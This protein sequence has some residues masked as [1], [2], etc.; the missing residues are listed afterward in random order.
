MDDTAPNNVTVT[1]SEDAQALVVAAEQRTISGRILPWNEEGSTSAGGLRF[2]PKAIRIPTDTSRVKLLRDH[3]PTGTPVGVMTAWETRTDGLYATFAIAPTADGDR[4]LVEA[5]EKVRDS[6][7]V[8]V[9]QLSRRG[10]DVLDSL[11]RGVAL[12][13]FPAFASALVDDVKASDHGDDSSSVPD[14]ADTDPENT[15]PA[16]DGENKETNMDPESVAAGTGEQPTETPAPAREAIVPTGLAPAPTAAP[17]VITASAAADIIL[18]IRNGDAD[19]AHAALVDITNTG[20]LSANPAAWLGKLWDGVVYQRRIIPAF[21]TA[22]LTGW[23]AAGW[24]WTTKP[25][26]DKYTGDK[27]D[28]PSKPATIE[29]V[30]LTAK[31]WAG[32]NDLD[33]KFID[34]RDTEFIA[35]YWE[36]MRESYAYETDKD[37]GAFIVA[38]AT[39][40]AVDKTLPDMIRAANHAALLIDQAVHIPASV[41]LVNPTDLTTLLDLS[42]LD[43]PKFDNLTPVSNPANWITS[44]FVEA[45]T[46]VVGAKQA[47]TFYELGGS[48]IR[49]EAEHIAKGGFDAGLFGYTAEMINRPEA[50]RLVNFG[51]VA[52]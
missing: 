36:A 42:A 11:L 52:P 26:V 19:E 51:S 24:K 14:D 38:E 45:G 32:A 29:P 43:A 39:K 35:A 6:F 33:R 13:A 30:E 21:Q 10:P 18:G 41:V 15:D 8:E 9:A 34:F 16:D 3:S 28:V 2:T 31:R 17:E 25:G 22:A 44:E 7:S 5:S 46:M 48:P 49:V 50:L 20:M 47:A 12:V 4:A 23:K 37:F 40:T 1:K 27:A